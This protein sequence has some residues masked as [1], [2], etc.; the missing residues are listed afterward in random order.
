MCNS[1]PEVAAPARH[2]VLGARPDGQ[3]QI[4]PAFDDGATGR[5]ELLGSA[6]PEVDA[7]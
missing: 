2:F 6:I 3:G 1:P 5:G 4:L 7:R